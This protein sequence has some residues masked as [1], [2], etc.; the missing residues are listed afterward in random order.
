MT[1]DPD[2]GLERPRGSGSSSASSTPTPV[3]VVSPFAPRLPTAMTD[4]LAK[5]AG[6]GTSSSSSTPSS[7]SSLDTSSVITNLPAA[8][9]QFVTKYSRLKSSIASLP[10]DVRTAIVHED[11]S[12]VQQGRAPMTDNETLAAIVTLATKK[13][14]TPPPEKRG[15]WDYIKDLPG[16]AVRDVRTILSSLPHLPEA[17][18]EEASQEL[19]NFGDRYR[20]A[21]A[22]THNPLSALAES[23]GIR[24]IPGALTVSNVAQGTAGLKNAAEH[25]V[26]QILDV[27]PYVG[28]AAE[29]TKV[30][31]IAMEE[32]RIGDPAIAQTTPIRALLTRSVVPEGEL[33]V[34]GSR[35]EPAKLGKVTE[36]MGRTRV[37]RYVTEAVGRQARSLSAIMGAGDA[38]LQ[39]V[40]QTETPINDPVLKM[41][42]D[43]YQL[44][45]DKVVNRF[46]LTDDEVR[47]VTDQ[48]AVDRNGMSSPKFTP[49]QQSFAGEA[50]KLH[51]QFE[52]FALHDTEKPLL[53]I[54]GEVYDHA[55]G[56][57]ILTTQERS[58]E[59]ADKT[60]S[61][62]F[63][64]LSK[65]RGE[66]LDRINKNLGDKKSLR[67]DREVLE[68]TDP[69]ATRLHQWL[70]RDTHDQAPPT[71]RE[72]EEA[73]RGLFRS[74]GRFGSS[75]V[76]EGVSE[77]RKPSAGMARGDMTLGQF[78]RFKSELKKL[79]ALEKSVEKQ[80]SRAP[81]RWHDSIIR[82][83]EKTS[84]ENLRLEGVD[85][86]EA[87]RVVLERDFQ[88][89]PDIFTAQSFKDTLREL[90]PLWQELKA[91]GHDPVYIHRVSP[92]AERHLA[93]PQT[94]D[95]IQTQLSHA[96]PR[97][98]FDASPYIHDV[99]I[100]LAHQGLEVAARHIS[101]TVM[102]DIAATFGRTE[103]QLYK[104][105]IGKAREYAA[106]NPAYDPGGAVK[107]LMQEDWVPFD[108]NAFGSPHINNISPASETIWLPKSIARNMERYYHPQPTTLLGATAPINGVFRLSVLP[109]RPAWHVNNIV[110]GAVVTGLENPRAFFKVGE[111]RDLIRRW[112]A[113]EDVLPR[114]LTSGMNVA[115]K[116]MA[117]SLY[118]V[119]RGKRVAELWQRVQS[120]PGVNAA[121]KL[122]EAS[123]DFNSFF[124][125]TYR[126][127]N[128][129]AELEKNIKSGMTRSE[130]EVTAL[131]SINRSFQ[132]WN[133]M[134]PIERNVLR[135][136]FPFYAFT[137]YALR[138]VAS[139]PG[140]HPLKAA[141]IANI[142]NSI[143][144]DYESQGLPLEM[145][146]FL[147][148]G[149]PSSTGDQDFI[150]LSGMNPFTD[151]ADQFT[152]AGFLS[153][154]GPVG[155]TVAS[156]TGA[157]LGFSPDSTLTYDPQT[158]RAVDSHPGLLPSLVGST[159][160]QVQFVQRLMGKDKD[161]NRLL[162]TNP[163]S[164]NRLLVSGLGLPAG[165]R[166][167][168]IPQQ[169]LTMEL[170]R[171][172]VQREVLRDALQS[173]DWSEAERWPNLR[174]LLE[175]V[176]ILR[177]QGALAPYNPT[178]GASP[179]GSVPTAVRGSIP[180]P[181]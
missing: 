161:F 76:G 169:Q 98:L 164:A 115:R 143:R 74:K 180:W 159:V 32:A 5:G 163:E 158:G 54:R 140:A 94:S 7:A 66:A 33:T 41:A 65:V 69:L 131:R 4:A 106:R 168:N 51:D 62:L 9:H 47:A 142:A 42:R 8:R 31:R 45:A 100:G 173:G 49:E 176:K 181:T 63:D 92:G 86:N 83:A 121:R 123:F 157:D 114:E 166:T 124:D 126:V 35:L 59:L 36:A 39:H 57:R 146:N 20:E 108:P 144:D 77:T 25:P 134:T 64:R 81:A 128:Y 11:V 160:P 21:L 68:R 2:F 147:A 102:G 120:L 61:E 37:G 125:D 14:A 122:V 137:G 73:S 27:A 67:V 112:R 40:L 70:N 58:L 175:Q 139:F 170:A 97:N 150:S 110:S 149:K 91:S 18:A 3:P 138:Y 50:V 129:Q 56:K 19:P 28:K 119:N 99:S 38:E 89:Y 153:G 152:L 174:P 30:G 104:A 117:Q 155:K 72:I 71:M 162:R 13:P 171:Q 172:R 1:L 46:N 26:T 84:V 88:A 113:G 118:E 107:L 167:I 78:G 135:Q 12:R 43:A 82:E 22:R 34:S 165:R 75:R 130:A 109:L 79:G 90:E 111:A 15:A 23:P 132:H 60:Y 154:L 156:V 101:T 24:F 52:D 103:A 55:T 80:L 136:A 29:A 179:V 95:L 10:E 105:L 177:D 151:T 44:A 178:A 141:V 6:T 93:F 145:L 53:K 116:E 16:A 133:A 87:A 48:L 17:V 148:I 127:M 96:K 85:P